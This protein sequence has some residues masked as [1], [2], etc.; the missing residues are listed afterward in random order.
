MIDWGK[1]PNFS[2]KEFQCSHCGAG[3]IREEVVAKLQAM[4]IEYGKPMKITSGYRCPQHP[5]EAKKS[6]PG[7]H[8][9][10][11]AAD[12]GVEG[13]EAH[14]ILGLAFLQGF[15]GIGV[16]QK[17]TGRFIHVDIRSGELPTPAVWSY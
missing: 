13:A 15:N 10:G 7:A 9:L 16:Q 5:I 17:G 11:L 3:G 8:A 1:Y 12:I 4:R 6:V 14:R 2:A